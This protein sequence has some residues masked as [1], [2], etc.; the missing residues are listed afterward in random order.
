MRSILSFSSHIFVRDLRTVNEQI[1][2]CV[3]LKTRTK[4]ISFS[5][6]NFFLLETFARR[7]VCILFVN[8]LCNRELFCIFEC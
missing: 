7:L 1:V 8:S 5:R 4:T 2:A 3:F 6:V